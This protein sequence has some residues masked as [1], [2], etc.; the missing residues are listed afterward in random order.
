MSEHVARPCGPFFSLRILACV[1]ALLA[2]DLRRVGRADHALSYHDARSVR[3]RL[4]RLQSCRLVR[5]CRGVTECV[6]RQ[7]AQHHPNW[8]PSGPRVKPPSG[9]YTCVVCGRGYRAPQS[10]TNRVPQLVRVTIVVCNDL[11]L[12]KSGPIIPH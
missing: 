11:L 2:G 3:A 8:D 6:C 12:V 1:V 7:I 4:H 5:F 10:N 9:G